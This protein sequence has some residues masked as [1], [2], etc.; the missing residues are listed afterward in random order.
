[1]PKV[2]NLSQRRQRRTEI[3]PCLTRIE[4]LVKFC[5]A[6]LEICVSRYG[7]RQAGRLIITRASFQKFINRLSHKVNN[8]LL[9]RVPH[10]PG[11]EITSPAWT[12][13]EL[14]VTLTLSALLSALT[15]S[16]GMEMT[17]EIPQ[18]AATMTRMRLADRLWMYSTRVTAQ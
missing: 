1:M 18:L 12:A 2:H 10:P 17:A 15:N 9:H 3:R 14:P 8:A 5:R 6:V 16:G 11:G 13:V 4:N 7:L